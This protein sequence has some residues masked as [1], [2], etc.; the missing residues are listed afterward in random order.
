MKPKLH[1]VDDW[2][3]YWEWFIEDDYIAGFSKDKEEVARKYGSDRGWPLP[4]V[5]AP[6]EGK[7]GEER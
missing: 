4:P 6:V 7:S 3:L 2:P 5:G 1:R